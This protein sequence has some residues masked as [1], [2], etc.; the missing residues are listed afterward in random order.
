M[1][2]TSTTTSASARPSASMFLESLAADY[3]RAFDIALPE[4][5]ELAVSAFLQDVKRVTGGRISRTSAQRLIL[6]N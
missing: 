6:G 2:T 1:N 4:C 5:L 3:R